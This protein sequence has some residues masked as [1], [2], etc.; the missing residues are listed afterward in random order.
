MGRDHMVMQLD[1]TA[2]TIKRRDKSQRLKCSDC[3]EPIR[4]R[5]EVVWQDGKPLH[6]MCAGFVS[7]PKVAPCTECF[8]IAP[9]LCVGI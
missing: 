2:T 8:T 3:N 9:C 1:G 4:L 7:A 6:L 5:K